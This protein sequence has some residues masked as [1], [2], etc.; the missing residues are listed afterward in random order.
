MDVHQNARLTPHCRALLVERVM[1][2]QGKQ[3]VAAQFRV[4]LATV[5]KWLRRYRA[6]G[7]SGLQDRSSRPRRSPSATARE[8]ELAVLALRRQRLTLPSSHFRSSGVLLPRATA[9]PSLTFIAPA[10]L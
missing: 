10:S 2:G 4:S 9:M 8:L 7:G 3:Q 6:E 1:R 5:Y